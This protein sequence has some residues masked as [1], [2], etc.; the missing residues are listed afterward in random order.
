MKQDIVQKQSV[1]IKDALNTLRETMCLQSGVFKKRPKKVESLDKIKIEV[2][3]DSKDLLNNKRRASFKIR[4]N[5]FNRPKFVDN[6]M[7]DP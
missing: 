6:S 2:D 3:S 4:I 1:E 5:S 7:Y